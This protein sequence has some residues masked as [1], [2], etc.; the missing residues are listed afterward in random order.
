MHSEDEMEKKEKKEIATT[1]YVTMFIHKITFGLRLTNWL[2]WGMEQELKC[3]K[4]KHILQQIALLSFFSLHLFRKYTYS[5]SLYWNLLSCF[6]F[7]LHTLP[8]QQCIVSILCLQTVRRKKNI[9]THSHLYTLNFHNVDLKC[10]IWR[11]KI[12][13]VVAVDVVHL[14]QWI[15]LIN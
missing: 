1:I 13:A 15:A 6:F 9:R 8:V 11:K 3:G 4:K 14:P 5:L 12:L 7:Y 10:V 2:T